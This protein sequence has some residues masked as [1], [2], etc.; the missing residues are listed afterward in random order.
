MSANKFYHK[1][2]LLAM[3][4]DF[5]KYGALIFVLSISRKFYEGQVNKGQKHFLN[6]KVLCK[7]TA[8]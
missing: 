4:F 7:Y 1:K 8:H 2:L 3:S 5:Q 6:C